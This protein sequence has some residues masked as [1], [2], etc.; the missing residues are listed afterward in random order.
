MES[1]TEQ[2]IAV[3]LTAGDP[4]AW[5]Q[6]Y[7]A[8]FDLIWRYV[9]RILGDRPADISDVVQ[10]I[11]LAAARSAR[12]KRPP[13]QTLIGWLYGIARNQVALFFRRRERHLAHF[14]QWVSDNGDQLCA[15]LSGPPAAPEEVLDR[16]ELSELVRLALAQLWPGYADLLANKYIDSMTVEQI[17]AESSQSCEAVRS[18]L[19][20]A[21]RAFRE[22]FERVA[23]ITEDVA[24]EG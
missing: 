16:S 24:Q 13:K 12:N 22:V 15:W 23:A 18:K 20:R 21:R 6:L 2:A 17:A 11:F 4:V 9:A 19:A 5:Q 8:H 1:R 7:D 14:P 10:E 3:G